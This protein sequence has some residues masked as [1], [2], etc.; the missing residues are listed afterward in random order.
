[1]RFVRPV[2]VGDTIRVEGEVIALDEKDAERGVVTIHQE[3]IN[4]HDETI[5]VLD[6]RTLHRKHR[7]ADTQN[8]P[9]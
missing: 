9:T 7:S 4:Q 1:M 5:A 6:K 3:I 8:V 2:F